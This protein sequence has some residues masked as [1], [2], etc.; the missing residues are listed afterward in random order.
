[1]TC[2]LLNNSNLPRGRC[3]QPPEVYRITATGIKQHKHPCLWTQAGSLSYFKDAFTA[4]GLPAGR[5]LGL[6]NA[7]GSLNQTHELGLINALARQNAGEDPPS[8]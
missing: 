6:I 7:I 8:A 1:M 2:I 5:K 4:S 3:P